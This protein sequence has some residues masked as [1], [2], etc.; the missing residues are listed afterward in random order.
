MIDTIE[1]TCEFRD[2]ISEGDLI[3]TIDGQRLEAEPTASWDQTRYFVISR[4]ST[5][6][7]QPSS[8]EEE[9]ANPLPRTSIRGM[10]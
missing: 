7:M 10:V 1:Q 6:D 8:E 2:R 9:T 4:T 3:I 5:N